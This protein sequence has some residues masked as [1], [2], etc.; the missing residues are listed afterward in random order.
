M[1][2]SFG[3]PLPSAAVQNIRRYATII[4]EQASA[5]DP[6]DETTRIASAFKTIEA[7]AEKI[8]EYLP[9]RE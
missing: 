4:T 8:L 2:D 1:P 9:E 3:H 7:A 6:E 5:V